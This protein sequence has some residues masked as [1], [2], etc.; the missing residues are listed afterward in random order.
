MAEL[1]LEPTDPGFQSSALPTTPQQFSEHEWLVTLKPTMSQGIPQLRWSLSNLELDVKA[2]P[3]HQPSQANT[4]LFPSPLP[5]K[6]WGGAL[7]RDPQ[8]LS[9]GA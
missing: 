6:W 1:G 4:A 7:R 9:L 2:S 5:Y 3:I 8:N